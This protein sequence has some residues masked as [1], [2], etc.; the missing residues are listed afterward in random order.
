MSDIKVPGFKS[1][2]LISSLNDAFKG[3]S[4]QQRQ[5]QIKKTNG[6]FEFQ[7]KNDKGETTSWIVDLKKKGEILKGPAPAGLKTDVTIIVSDEDFVDMGTG[8][9]NGQKAFMTG[10]LKTKGNIMLA[11]KLDGLFKEATAGG[12]AKL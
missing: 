8:K 9:L 3:Y 5:A 10:K 4:E 12:K 7:I 11:T 1:S 6:V 2:D